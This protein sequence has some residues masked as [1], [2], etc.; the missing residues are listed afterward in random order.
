MSEGLLTTILL[1]FNHNKYAI[2][3]FVGIAISFL[4][5]IVKPAR[6]NAVL[7]FA[8]LLLFVG[9]EYDKHIE[10]SLTDQTLKSLNSKESTSSKLASFG[11]KK[12]LPLFFYFFGWGSLFLALFI[13]DKD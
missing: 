1:T 3:F 11:T 8:F 7:L 2:A 4:L 9:F 10:D 6:K 13:K 5:L 12:A